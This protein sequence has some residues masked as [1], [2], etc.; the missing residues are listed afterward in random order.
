MLI[1][2][3]E[4]LPI[5][6]LGQVSSIPERNGVDVLWIAQ[7]HRCG[8]QRKEIK[9]FVASVIDGRLYKEILQMTQLQG[10]R[11]LILEG[12]FVWAPDGT[13]TG[14]VRGWDRFRHRQALFTLQHQNIWVIPTESMNDTVEAI[15]ELERWSRKTSHQF[16][17]S[18]AKA[19]GEWGKPTSRE[20]G[21]HLLMSFPGVGRD[22]AERV[23]SHFGR[24]PLA[25]TVTEDE[26]QE[27]DGIGPKRAAAMHQ[28]LAALAPVRA[29]ETA[30]ETDAVAD[31]ETVA[32]AEPVPAKK[33]RR[34]TAAA[35]ATATTNGDGG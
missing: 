8:V 21:L 17:A 18:R 19:T 30:T 29:P 7:G 26:L 32:V 28:A 14:P 6:R 1:A 15:A 13:W 25:W 24:V 23:W 16:T 31:T 33:K 22:V 3:S 10:V 35:T 4:P 9:D 11:A 34:K 20:F 12:H 2:P 5:K 27:V